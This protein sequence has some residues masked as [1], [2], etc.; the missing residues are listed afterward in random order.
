[1]RFA[2]RFPALLVF[3]FLLASALRAQTDVIGVYLTW[4]RDP[5]T[6]AVVN[7][8]NLYE[9]APA[10]VWHRAVGETAWRASEGTR[11][12]VAPSVLQVRR[13]EL[14]GLLADTVYEFAIGETA[15]ADTKGVERFRTVPAGLNRPVK[16]V[17]GGDTMHRREWFD[18]MNRA[19]GATDPDFALIGGDLAYANGRDASRWIDW[20]RSVHQT[21]RAPDGRL[22]PIVVAIGNHEVRGYYN[23]R[24][25]D[26]APYFYGLFAL[27]ENRSYHTLDFG[28]YLSLVILDTDHTQPI[29]GAQTE[30]LAAALAARADR[31]F[32]FPCYHYP[33]YGTT[34][35]PKEG[36]LP[37][38]HPRSLAIRREWSP[39]FEK[40]AVTAVFEN[41]HHAY[42]R[43]HPILAGKR[44]DVSGVVYLGDG[45]WGVEVRPVATPEEAWYLARSEAR[46]HVFVV[47]L[48][49][50]G[51]AT[52]QAIDVAGA[53]FDRVSLPG[54]AAKP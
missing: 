47:T 38:E 12:A 54:R 27:P 23:G 50:G 4:L 22:I 24:V 52:V 17:S 37:S 26:D 2:P 31:A 6:S 46:R 41:D 43:T 20:L 11:A 13:V 5:S 32:V 1:M 34:K 40:H 21:L 15:P 51:E 16:F 39:L 53:V 42:K 36:G 45:A 14:T 10:R 49:A 7:W 30:W 28:T 18:A 3:L 25:P 29:A 9:H 44:D 19:A 33:A 48:R 8:V 35:R